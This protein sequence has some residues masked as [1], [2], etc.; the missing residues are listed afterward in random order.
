VVF[1]QSHSSLHRKPRRN[2]KRR[3]KRGRGGG[4]E[5]MRKLCAEEA[6]RL[7]GTVNFEEMNSIPPHPLFST[8][9]K[10]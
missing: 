4:G 7:I 9:T 8:D 10:K 6:G 3:K 2:K 5:L 1:A